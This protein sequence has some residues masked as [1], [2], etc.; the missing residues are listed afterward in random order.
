V[1]ENHAALI[2]AWLQNPDVI[3]RARATLRLDRVGAGPATVIA[4]SGAS[5]HRD[6]ADRMQ[7]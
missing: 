6:V 5:R 4:E 1:T 7:R 3:G 2:V